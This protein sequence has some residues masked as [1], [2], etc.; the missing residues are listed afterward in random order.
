[1]RVGA[2]ARVRVR[3]PEGCSGKSLNGLATTR[4]RRRGHVA[5]VD[6]HG[7]AVARAWRG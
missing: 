2:V 4:M 5:G 6:A 7:E 1:V 3:T